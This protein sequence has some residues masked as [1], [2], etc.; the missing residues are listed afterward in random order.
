MKSQGSVFDV[1]VEWKFSHRLYAHIVLC[2]TH[3]RYAYAYTYIDNI[4]Y[5]IFHSCVHIMGARLC[6][7]N[8]HP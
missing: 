5:T 2:R 8:V 7:Y 3:R 4:F 1:A 6:L